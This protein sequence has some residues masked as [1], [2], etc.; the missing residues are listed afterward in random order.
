M[1]KLRPGKELISAR[2]RLDLKCTASFVVLGTQIGNQR[3]GLSAIGK[4]G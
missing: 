2:Y 3:A 4:I 1:G